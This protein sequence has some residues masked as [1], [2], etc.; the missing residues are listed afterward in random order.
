MRAGGSR[1][2]SQGHEVPPYLQRALQVVAQRVCGCVH[3]AAA[4]GQHLLARHGRGAAG[5]MG[6]RGQGQ[7]S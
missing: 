6:G 4:G 2:Q 7:G 5:W 3:Q 1:T